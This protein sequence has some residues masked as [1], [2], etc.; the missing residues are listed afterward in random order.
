[1]QRPRPV[2][3]QEQEDGHA[4]DGHQV[5]RQEDDELEDLPEAERAVHAVPEGLPQPLDGVSQVAAALSSRDQGRLDGQRRHGPVPA[6]EVLEAA[7]DEHGVEDVDLGL[8]DEE[9]F[10]EEGDDGGALA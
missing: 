6:D 8:V 10:E 7:F 3:G 2:P 4:D 9:G 1:M 5:Q